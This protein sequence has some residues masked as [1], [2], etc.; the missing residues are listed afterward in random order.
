MTCYTKLL[1]LVADFSQELLPL[2]LVRF[3]FHTLRR[4]SVNDAHDS[5]TQ[6]RFG[7]NNLNRVCRGA[8]NT[9]HFVTVAHLGQNIEGKGIP[10]KDDEKVSGPN[11]LSISDGGLDEV[12]I[13]SI[14]SDETL[15]GRLTK[16]NAEFYSGHGVD[17]GLVK[18]LPRLDKVGMP[19]NNVAFFRN[20]N[21][22]YFYIHTHSPF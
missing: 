16:S 13:V 21:R 4:R 2:L 6:L 14:P 5:P 9:H 17:H 12:V 19:K 22:Y 11:V 3:V 8:K 10:Q 15:L 20:V 18:I 7:N 1:S